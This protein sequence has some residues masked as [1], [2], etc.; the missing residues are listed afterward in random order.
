MY[1]SFLIHSSADG[2]LGC[3]HVVY[4]F[5][6]VLE[7]NIIIP[8]SL[9]F[10]AGLRLGWASGIKDRVSTQN[11][12][13]RTPFFFSFCSCSFLAYASVL[14]VLIFFQLCR[15]SCSVITITLL[16]KIFIFL[17]C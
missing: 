8:P 10:E 11:V 6:T 15:K 9:N 3:F 5:C 14:S 4:T 12:F 16:F 1:H 13:Y 17:V 7:D 2:H